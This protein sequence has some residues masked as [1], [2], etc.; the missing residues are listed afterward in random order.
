MTF[1]RRFIF[2]ENLN[3]SLAISCLGYCKAEKLLHVHR[4]VKAKEMTGKTINW[5]K[6]AFL[7]IKIDRNK[8]SQLGCS[9]QLSCSSDLCYSKRNERATFSID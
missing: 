6:K 3:V 8:Q 2:I 4:K 5:E 9:L 1:F 7:L